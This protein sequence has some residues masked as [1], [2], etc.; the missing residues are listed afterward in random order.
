ML[1]SNTDF[2]QSSVYWIL[3]LLGGWITGKSL[4]CSLHSLERYYCNP[5]YLLTPPPAP[6]V[7]KFKLEGSLTMRQ[8]KKSLMFE[9]EVKVGHFIY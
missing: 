5:L 4:E 7:L 9:L 8:G 2:R 6:L 3:P 1:R